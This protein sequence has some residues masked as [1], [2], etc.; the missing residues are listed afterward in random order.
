MQKKLCILGMG[1]SSLLLSWVAT[2]AQDLVFGIS[3]NNM[4]YPYNVALVDGFTKAAD[5]V[6]VR[7]VVMDSKSSLE[8][9]ANQ[10]DDMLSQKMNGIAFMPNDSVAVQ[11][12]VDKAADAG[13]PIVAAAVP[14]GEPATHPVNYVYPTLTALVTTNDVTAGHVAGEMAAGML[15]PDREATIAVVEG[16]PGFS[17]VRQRQEG[18]EAALNEAGI[19]FR[20][21]ASQPTDW[22]PESGE[23]VCQ[24]ILTA[25]PDV[26]LIF[27]HADPMAVGCALAV[28][29]S[30]SNAMLISTGGGS[31]DGNAAIV[32]GDLDGSV[33]TKPQL[34]GE[35]SFK[36]LYEAVI[37]PAQALKGQ[38]ISY[39]LLPLTQANVA[40][41]PASGW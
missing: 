11:S 17:V 14:V 34:I 41:C 9:Q 3:P 30:G 33:C 1:L 2:S 19:K 22:T 23:A 32:A 13:V 5:A 36:A 6:G 26:D 20:I 8:T 18:F 35:L 25:N 4:A 38:Y 15:P 24:N 27:S 37:N 29:A 31:T 12:L 21:V 39:N 16:A 7:V 40:E 28:N 10:F